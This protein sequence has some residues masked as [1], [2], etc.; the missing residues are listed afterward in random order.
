MRQA[1]FTF[2]T[3]DRCS[4]VRQVAGKLDGN[5]ITPID[6]KILIDG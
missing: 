2:A 4:N 1:L 3:G 5:Q 6:K